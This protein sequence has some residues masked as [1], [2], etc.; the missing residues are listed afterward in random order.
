M[1]ELANLEAGY[2]PV[3]SKIVKCDFYVD[4]LISGANTED[5]ARYLINEK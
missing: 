2:Y 1:H 5:E 3:E 4:D